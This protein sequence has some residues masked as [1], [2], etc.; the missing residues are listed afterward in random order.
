M[1]NTYTYTVGRERPRYRYNRTTF[2]QELKEFLLLG[3]ST[4]AI[5][6]V[7]C[8]SIYTS[9]NITEKQKKLDDFKNTIRPVSEIFDGRELYTTSDLLEAVRWYLHNI[10]Y[11][12]ENMPDEDMHLMTPVLQAYD[13]LSFIEGS[14]LTETMTQDQLDSLVEELEKVEI[15]LNSVL[16]R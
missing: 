10:T 11:I 15:Y 3:I 1:K 12:L 8:V 5:V 13:E 9:R 16:E 4:L 2:K 7:I 14:I 6:A